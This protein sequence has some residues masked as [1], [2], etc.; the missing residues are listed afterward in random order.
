MANN[1]LRCN[2]FAA[3]KVS[4]GDRRLPLWGYV[5]LVILVISFRSPSSV[6][7]LQEVSTILGSHT[8]PQ[9]AVNVSYLSPNS[10]PHSLFPLPLRLN[11]G[12]GGTDRPP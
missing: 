4:F 3:L 8:T 12:L 2:L 7:L 6:Y 11:Q 5:C 10:L 1:S 9:I